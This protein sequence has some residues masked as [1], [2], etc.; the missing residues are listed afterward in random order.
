[1]NDNLGALAITAASVGFL[2]TICGP[3][4][5]LPFVAMS[6]VGRWSLRKTTAITLLCGVGHV[7]S[8][9]ALGFVGIAFGVLLFKLEHIEES[10]GNVAA[11]LLIAFGW[12][13]AVWGIVRAVRNQPHTHLHVHPDGTVHEHEHTHQAEHLHPHAAASCTAQGSGSARSLTPWVLLTIFLFGPCEPL[14]PMVMYPAAQ[15]NVWGVVWI[16]LLFGLTTLT[17]MTGMVLLMY[18]GVGA[19]RWERMHRYSHALAGLVVLSCGVAI[20]MGL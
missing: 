7:A 1:M 12:T 5:Y 2:H 11:W 9:V 8:S 17:T 19:L 3:D 20:K 15:A 14:I 16:T 10:R 13:Y 4:H 18:H 6:R